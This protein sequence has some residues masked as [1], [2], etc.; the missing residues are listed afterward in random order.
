MKPDE[1]I[2]WRDTKL[3]ADQVLTMIAATCIDRAGGEIRIT[4]AEWQE[5]NERYG[6][7][8]AI[9]FYEPGDGEPMHAWIDTIA[10]AA[11]QSDR[12]ETN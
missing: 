2:E 1:P 8:A 7:Q 10:G 3:R 11:Q 5:L 4:H 6:G 9:R 12:K